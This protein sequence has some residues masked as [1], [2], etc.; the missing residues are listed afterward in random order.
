MVQ[1]C[2]NKHKNWETTLKSSLISDIQCIG[3]KT[4]KRGCMSDELF[5]NLITC[6]LKID[7]DIR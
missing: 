2:P 3:K 5:I 1:G 4:K 6:N 7:K